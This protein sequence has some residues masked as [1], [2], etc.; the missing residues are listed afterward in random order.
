VIVLHAFAIALQIISYLQTI[1]EDNVNAPQQIPLGIVPW[2]RAWEFG[3]AEGEWSRDV[4][5]GAVLCSVISV[6][7]TLEIT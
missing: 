6:I 3:E 5:R 2:T 4:Y 1:R 7:G